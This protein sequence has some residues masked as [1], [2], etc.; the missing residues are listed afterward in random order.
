LKTPKARHAVLVY[1]KLAN[2]EYGSEADRMYL[3][4]LSMTLEQAFQNKPVGEFDGDEIGNG[5]CTLY[6]YGPDAEKLFDA[7]LQSIKRF[8]YK[9][10]SYAIKRLGGKGAPQE[11]IEI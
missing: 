4:D 9:R 2:D 1:L 3:K 8:P 7:A 5:F 11:K 10:G 6:F